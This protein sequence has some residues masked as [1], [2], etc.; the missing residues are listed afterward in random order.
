MSEG[1]AVSEANAESPA[2]LETVMDGTAHTSEIVMLLCPNLKCR[3]VLRV[4]TNCRGK[5]VRCQFCQLTF[6]VPLPRPKDE[7]PDD[8][9]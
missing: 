4:P 7:K 8:R 6:E 3:K 9:V 2:G 5:V 1:G